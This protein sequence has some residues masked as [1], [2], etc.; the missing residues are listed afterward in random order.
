MRASIALL[1][2]SVLAA[3]VSL[4]AAQETERY[5]LERTQDGYVR[6]DTATGRVTLC[7]ERDGQLVCRMAVEDRAAYDRE[8]DALQDRIEALERRVAV[9]ESGRPAAQLPDEQEFEQTLGY[10]E[11]FFRRFMGIVKD[12]ERDFGGTSTEPERVPDRT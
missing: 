5:Q 6:L 9:L 11:R 12:F 1:C 8:F 4:A 7:Q 2:S 3:S 10:M